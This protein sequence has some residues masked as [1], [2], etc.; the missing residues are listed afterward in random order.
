MRT[1]FRQRDVPPTTIP[2]A[3]TALFFGMGVAN[4]I[5]QLSMPAVGRG[6]FESR[7][8]SGSAY[9]R[10]IKRQ[11]TTGQYLAVA[12]VGSTSDK[13][14]YHTAVR[15]V[16]RHVHSTADSPVRYSANDPA[17][18]QWVAMCLFKGFLDSW[19]LTYGVLDATARNHLLAQG[20]S[21]GTTLEMRGHDW[22]ATYEEFERRW[23]ATLPKLS[24]DDDVRGH[25]TSLADLSF[26]HSQWGLAGRIVSRALGPQLKFMTRATLPTEF[27]AMMGWTWSERDQRKFERI[28]ALHRAVDFLAP[29]LSPASLRVYIV[30][31]RVRQAFGLPTLGKLKVRP[32]A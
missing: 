16:H 3:T 15:E 14:A 12:I 2:Q 9:R 26:L 8:D 11:R 4:I 20:K 25:L 17:L 32:A 10:V 24:I 28:V 6:V 1:P 18:Q 31:L 5:M 13:L 29:W 27:R 22:P 21:L 19:E 7:V 30:D 23:A